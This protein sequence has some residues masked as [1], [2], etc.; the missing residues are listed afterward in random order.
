[1]NHLEEVDYTYVLFEG[2]PME[3]MKCLVS[4]MIR[5]AGAT[6]FVI[7]SNEQKEKDFCC[8]VLEE[9]AHIETIKEKLNQV[10]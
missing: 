9:G 5:D 2:A 6:P 1:M 7:L 10:Q 8:E 3:N 4:D